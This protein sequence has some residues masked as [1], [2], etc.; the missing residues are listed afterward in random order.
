MLLESPRKQ[1]LTL[2]VLQVNG[3]L[4]EVEM[5][6]AIVDLVLDIDREDVNDPFAVVDYVEDIYAFYRETEVNNQNHCKWVLSLSSETI[7]LSVNELF[8]SEKKAAPIWASC[9]ARAASALI[10]CPIRLTSTRR[11]GPS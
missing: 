10:T 2:S 1:R 11:C 7:K 9:R 6:D 4:K 5:E 3:E 8:S